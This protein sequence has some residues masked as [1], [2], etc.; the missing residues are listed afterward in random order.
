MSGLH[1]F[2]DQ[3]DIEVDFRGETLHYIEGGQRTRMMWFWTSGYSVDAGSIT[4]W[5]NADGSRTAVTEDERKTILQRVVQY[6]L[7]KQN[8]K[9]KVE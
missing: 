9:L 6:A 5:L 1:Q 4:D 3:F 7:E 2:T 8:V